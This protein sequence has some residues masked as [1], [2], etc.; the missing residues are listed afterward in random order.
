MFNSEHISIR[1]PLRTVEMVDKEARRIGRT[2]SWVIAW[3]LS[4]EALYGEREGNKN[5]QPR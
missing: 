1:L 2:R 4:D 5:A 3:I